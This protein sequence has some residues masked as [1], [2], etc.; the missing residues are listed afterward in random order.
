MTEDIVRAALVSLFA[1]DVTA[2]V[3]QVGSR[4][5]HDA[6]EL[7]PSLEHCIFRNFI[8][9]AAVASTTMALSAVLPSLLRRQTTGR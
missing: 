9:G 4:P 2:M 3:V 5:W 8:K 1:I 7:Y 6:P